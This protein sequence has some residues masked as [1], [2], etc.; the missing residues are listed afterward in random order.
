VRTQ[1]VDFLTFED[2][3]LSRTRLSDDIIGFDGDRIIAWL[4]PHGLFLVIDAVKV[5]QTDYYT[6]TNLWHTQT[7][8]TQGQHY[9]DTSIDSIQSRK[10]PQGKRLLV[11]FLDN[12]AKQDSLYTQTRHFQEEKAVY[13]TRSSHYRAGDWDVFITVLT[14]HDSGTAVT[15]LL[16]RVKMLD[17]TRYPEAV[18]FEI[19]DSNRVSYV[20]FKLDLEAEVVRENIR[21]RYTW[22][23]GRTAYGPIE[24]DAHFL[25]ATVSNGSLRYA[26]SEVLKVLYEGRPLLEALP[27]THGLQ[28]DGAADRVGYV[29]WR[30]W[31]DTV[32]IG[33]GSR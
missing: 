14:P 16:E 29:K 22:E 13:Q 24:T 6:F 21:P 26:A 19:S 33:R 20:G 15:P 27:N 30:F 28:L 2:V 4:K 8:H 9:Y 10:L 7:V 1:K 11:Q 23:A 17:G 18:G 5:R 3:E 32:D 12:D 31:E 25:Y